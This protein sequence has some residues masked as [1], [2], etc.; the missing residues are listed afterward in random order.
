MQA[1]AA[2]RCNQLFAPMQRLLRAVRPH[3][4]LI[5]ARTGRARSPRRFQGVSQDELEANQMLASN[6]YGPCP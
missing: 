2:R 4:Q 3:R 1:L 6:A 5:M